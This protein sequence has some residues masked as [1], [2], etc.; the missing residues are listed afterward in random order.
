MLLVFYIHP[1]YLELFTVYWPEMLQ[2]M[3]ARGLW[4]DSEVIEG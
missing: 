1:D 4:D 3:R 2:W